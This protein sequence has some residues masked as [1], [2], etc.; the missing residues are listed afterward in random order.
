MYFKRYNFPGQQVAVYCVN[1]R[2]TNERRRRRG[3]GAREEVVV[4][5]PGRFTVI[6]SPQ[7]GDFEDRS[8]DQL[9]EADMVDF[10]VF[11]AV[12]LTLLCLSS[13]L[14]MPYSSYASRR[15][16]ENIS[17]DPG[18]CA[19]GIR[20]DPDFTSSNFSLDIRMPGVT[21][22]ESDNYLCISQPVPSGRDSYIVDFIP[23]A[24]MDTV[25]H[26]L[27]FGCRKPS[28]ISG[29]WDCGGAV[30]A[31]EDQSSIMYAWGRNAPSTKLP[32]DVGFLVGKNSKMPYLV[33]QIHYGDIKAFRDHHRDCSG[34]TLT[35]T[36]KPQP[37]IAGIYLLLSY[38]TVIPPG[39]K[40]TN[41]DVACDYTSFPIY[42]FAFR[43]HTH[44]LGKVVTGYRVRNG[45]WTLIG[46]QSPQLPQAFYPTNKD[47]NVKYGDTVAARCMFTGENMTTAT[48]IGSTSNDEMCNFYIMYYMDRKHAIPFMTCMNPGPKQLF[49]HIPAE[50]NIPIPVSPDMMH[51]G[52]MMHSAHVSG[53]QDSSSLG[54]NTEQPNQDFHLEQVSWPLTSLQLGQVS[55]LAYNI[56][57]Y[58]VVFHRGDRRWG[59]N[60]FNLQERYQ[61]RF[62]GPIQQST[63]L[64]V[65][66]DVGAVMKAS[67][68]NMFYLPHGI[69]TDKD[70]NYWLTDVALHQVFKVSG[71]GRDRILV[72][73]G[74]AFVPG[75]DSGHF[76]KP[77]DV[78]VDSKTGNVFVS[79]GYC[80]A[81]ILKFSP[82]G[83]Y[84]NEWGAGASD[85]GRR[86]P[87]QIPHSLA[88]I[89]DRQ[90]LCVADRENG[91]I[92]CF[93]AETGEFVK[94]IKKEEFGGKV[95]AITYSPGGDGMLYAV[96]GVSPHHSAPVRGFVMSYYSTGIVDTFQPEK[97]EFQMPHD[98]VEGIDGVYVGDLDSRQIYKFTL[99]K[100]H[101]SVK[102]GGIDVQQLDEL[103]VI[104][105][106]EVR[107]QPNRTA[108]VDEKAAAAVQPHAP[109]EEE[110]KEREAS[111]EQTALPVL[112]TVLL[113]V[114]LLL[115]VSTGLFI[116]WRRKDQSELKSEP[117]SVGGIFGKI[118]GKAVGGLNLGNFF[119]SHRGYT[120][121]G[122]DQ[123]STEGSD[124]ER[125]NESSDSE[126]EEFSTLPPRSSS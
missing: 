56:H 4:D 82:E 59:A 104:V 53:H 29:Y 71:N 34:I 118:R 10:P 3:G 99:E 100:S 45:E 85:S 41:A 115:I 66:P 112:I 68:R 70:N 48:S 9:P 35:M 16:W 6:F 27:L 24:N 25:H 97:K 116:C 67:G 76:C 55:G 57:S 78:A 21:P 102:K 44:H 13:S 54:T 94:E 69:T 61:E 58:L 2:L 51:A 31:C 95:F 87:F 37:F 23:H 124:Q 43:T 39:N 63:I 79:D 62:L 33:L 32:R 49:Q 18:G 60:S 109:E 11:S 64:V 92:Q 114:P 50:A 89:P 117:S 73:L 26:M 65:D 5:D 30:G 88:F 106:A 96:N 125:N 17:K 84:L 22:A 1:R 77:T 52:H 98:I 126:Y 119:V 15:S 12:V 14:E 91:R 42:P 72:T 40:V 19:L 113:L 108:V 93:I 83:K 105:K 75:S 80:N 38:N 120:R 110:Q 107:P 103:Q 86:I 111:K 74:E 7:Q 20:P 36:Y 81:R 121:Q 8:Q 101:R 46:R 28:S 122:F 47:V 123:L 90:E